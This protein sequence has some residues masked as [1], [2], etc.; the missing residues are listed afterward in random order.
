MAISSASGVA[1]PQTERRA[2]Q[3][4][5]AKSDEWLLR[6][7]RASFRHAQRVGHWPGG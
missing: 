7:R 1:R 5:A 6:L 4:L 2:G 3:Q